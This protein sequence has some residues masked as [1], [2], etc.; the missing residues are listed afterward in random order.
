MDNIE[1]H[2]RESLKKVTKNLQH[3]GLASY[4][5]SGV[6]ITKQTETNTGPCSALPHKT[7]PGATELSS[8]HWVDRTLLQS[9]RYDWL[10]QQ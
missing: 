2:T 6:S 1:K 7:L 10:H 4:G 9:S 5:R 8:K 3:L